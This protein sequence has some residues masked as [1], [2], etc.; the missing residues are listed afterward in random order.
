M[1]FKKIL[2][3]S[4]STWYHRLLF[5]VYQSQLP[6]VEKS[7]ALGQIV[8]NCTVKYIICIFCHDI[9]TFSVSSILVFLPILHPLSLFSV[10][11]HEQSFI[12]SWSNSIIEVVEPSFVWRIDLEPAQESYL[13]A[14]RWNFEDS[15]LPDTVKSLHNSINLL[16]YSVW[17]TLF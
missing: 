12:K 9:C 5:Q 2:L 4:F 16:K 8:N 15:N 17:F 11:V 13:L 14:E 6:T 3:F 1:Q 10:V 7:C